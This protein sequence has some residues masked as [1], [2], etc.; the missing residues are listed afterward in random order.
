MDKARMIATGVLAALAG[1]LGILAA[2]VLV[3]LAVETADYVTGIA[4]APFRGQPVSS[5]KSL[6]GVV[7][8]LCLLLLVGVG[9]VLDWLIAFAA[10]T[11]GIALPFHF[12]IAC[13]AAVWLICGEVISILENVRDMGVSL[14]PFLNAIARYVRTQAEHKAS[15]PTSSG[16]SAP[17]SDPS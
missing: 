7:K 10:E 9:G 17:P 6:K 4:A 14:P 1:K 15:L 5:A 2:P 12:L 8:K 13:V 16:S 11:V 3:L